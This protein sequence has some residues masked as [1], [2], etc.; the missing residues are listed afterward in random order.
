[1]SNHL[2]KKTKLSKESDMR[3]Y[4]LTMIDIQGQST[5]C[6]ANH[7]LIMKGK[8]YGLNVKRKENYFLLEQG[9]KDNTRLYKKR[10]VQHM[11]R[12]DNYDIAIWFKFLT[13]IQQV[14][15]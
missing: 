10:K 4:Q 15:I 8:S 7:I 9:T 5:D 6:N 12:S 2:S 3:P 11:A 13:S 14:N 1:M